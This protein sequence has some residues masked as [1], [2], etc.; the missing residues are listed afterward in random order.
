M[1]QDILGSRL[2]YKNCSDLQSP[3]DSAILYNIQFK[4]EEILKEFENSSGSASVCFLAKINFGVRNVRRSADKMTKTDH[5]YR[6]LSEEHVAPAKLKTEHIVRHML[7]RHNQSIGNFND[8]IS[9][10]SYFRPAKLTLR[11]TP[12]FTTKIPR[13]T[14]GS[15]LLSPIWSN[16]ESDNG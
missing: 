13:K 5:V 7:V 8:T 14:I 4:N 6:G 9:C 2:N 12:R 16:A 15:V 1:T 10:H 3:E 11:Y